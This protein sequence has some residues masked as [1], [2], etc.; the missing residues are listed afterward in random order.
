LASQESLMPL[1]DINAHVGYRGIAR[2]PSRHRF[3]TTGILLITTIIVATAALI[4][5]Q[6]ND[7][8]AAYGTATTNLGNGMSQQTAQA[9][10]SIDR[11]LHQI[12]INLT[13]AP[14]AAAEQIGM[15]MRTKASFD[16]LVSSSKGT[17]FVTGLAI[18]DADGD[19]GNSTDNWTFAGRDASK[20]NFFSYFRMNDDHN[21]FV[22]GPTKSNVSKRWIA[23]ISRRINDG[24]GVFAGTVVAEISLTSIEEF[25]SGAM[26]AHRSVSLVRRDGVVLVRF[27]H[28]EEEI[29]KKIPDHA[30]WYSAVAQGG[31]TYH[32]NDYF[33]N[34]PI[35][36]FARPL[37]NLPLV[38]QAS[39]SEADVLVDWPRQVLWLVLGAASAI[40]GLVLLLRHLARQVDRLEQSGAVLTSKNLELE[41]AHGQL[42]A[43]LANISLGVCFFSGEKKLIVSNQKYRDI[44]NLPPEAIRPGTSLAEV[45]DYRLASGSFSRVGREK[46]VSSRVAMVATGER[47]QS[48]VELMSGQTVF[49]T[50]QPMPHGGWI[51][52]HEDI[53]ER[54]E[55]DR[56]IRFLAHHD[57]LT[58]LPNRAFFTEKLGE[59]VARLQRHGESFTVL[60]MDLDK[61]KNVNDTLGHPAGDQ[62][63]SE[64]AQRLKSSLRDTDV[65]ARLGGDEFAIIQLGEENPREG[66]AGLAARILKLISE[67]FDI[68]GHV[69]FVGSSIGIALAP[70]NSGNSSDLLKMADL[71]LYAVKEAGRNNFRFF[72]AEMLAT[73]DSR[74][75][76]EDELRVAISR[77]EF[78]LH[79][80]AL[81]DVK[82]GRQAGFEALVRWLSP[83]RGRVMPDQFIPLAEE[84]GLIVPLGEWILQRACADAANWPSQ[85]KVAVN[86]SPVQL[87]QPD[88][89]QSVQRALAE[90][91]LSPERLELEIT[92]TALFKGDADS[93]KLIRKLKKL[94]ISIALDDFGTGYSSLSYLTMVPFDKIKIDRSF[95]MNMTKR[96]DCAAIVAAVVA[97]GQSL[98]TET[99]AEGVETEQQLAILRTAGVTMV[100]GYLFGVPCPA[101]AL[102]LDGLAKEPDDVAKE[103]VLA[104][105]A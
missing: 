27:P 69:V 8:I 9:L 87:A 83:T 75:A 90:S 26:P 1:K 76:L 98:K 56:H 34:T 15:V 46:F 48:V 74:R 63:L 65:L 21:S 71:A 45:Q 30:P 102:V 66:A 97:L 43:A 40:V 36:A 25:Y 24:H 6:R 32:S 35:V 70:E 85:I 60:M 54:R 13:S 91:G 17:S 47:Q 67:P 80:Q 49:I 59:A 77:G 14:D 44:Y 7:A 37:K 82:T 64:T 81:I 11:T 61:F 95:T 99:V 86:L 103:D 58:G 4:W 41:T 84:T 101:S 73:L 72:E 2:K 12:G 89:F 92:E 3:M 28:R 50:H 62:L 52:T 22:S 79:Y 51:S 105:A 33:T 38:V 20:Q 23:Y 53:T 88:L 39:V 93:I 94:G 55:A 10:S 18:V 19:I 42:D 96:A 16:L 100:Q 29:G 104:S 68:D 31:A 57:V 5:M 78:E